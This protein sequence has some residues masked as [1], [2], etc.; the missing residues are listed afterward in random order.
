VEQVLDE[1]VF[2]RTGD[3]VL[4]KRT[5]D[6]REETGKSVDEYFREVFRC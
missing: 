5:D 2:L 4:H 6:I 1:A 3:I